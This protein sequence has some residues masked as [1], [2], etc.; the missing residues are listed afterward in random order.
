MSAMA[1][2]DEV[3]RRALSYPCAEIHPWAPDCALCT[4]EGGY[5][6]APAYLDLR[7][8]RARTEVAAEYEAD[9]RARP[10]WRRLLRWVSGQ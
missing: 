1:Y 6:V 3:V 10:I 8:Q 7:L 5:V 4:S 9:R 2:S